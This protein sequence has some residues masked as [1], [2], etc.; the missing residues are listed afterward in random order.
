V[1]DP[2]GC[3]FSDFDLLIIVDREDL[4]DGEFGHEAEIRTMAVGA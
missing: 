2:V 3:D 1:V 4:T